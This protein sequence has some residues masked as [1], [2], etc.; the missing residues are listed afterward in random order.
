MSADDYA[1]LIGI[2]HY[3]T[4][5]AGDVSADLQGP[6]NDVDAI[7]AWLMQPD[8]G[9]INDP[10]HIWEFKSA[11]ALPPDTAR[12]TADELEVAVARIDAIAQANVARQK[13]PRVGRRLYIFVSGH[14]YSPKPRLGCLFSANAMYRFTYNV[15]ITGWLSCLQDAAYFREYVLWMDCCMNRYSFL[16]PR[17]PPLPPVN[18]PEPPGANF[19]AFAAQRPLKAVEVPIAED[20]GKYHGVFTWA[21]LEGLRGAAS[22]AN[23]RVTGRSLADWIRNAQYARMDPLDRSN[24]DVAKE[25]EVVQEDASIVFARGLA[26]PFYDVSVAFASSEG[27]LARLWSGVSPRTFQ[28]IDLTGEAIQ[29]SLQPGLYLID[30]PGANLRQGFEVVGSTKVRIEEVGDPVTTVA[31]D[32]IFQLDIDPEDPT[33]EIYVIDSRFALVDANP[34]TLSTPL[35]F[36]LY[37]IKTRVGRTIS[38]KIILHDCDHP[39]IQRASIAL[40]VATVMPISGTTNVQADHEAAKIEGVNAMHA[41]GLSGHRCALMLMARSFSCQYEPVS[42]TT[43]WS[44][45]SIVDESGETVIDLEHDADHLQSC[46]GDPYAVCVRAVEPGT[47]FLK[48]TLADGSVIEQSLVVCDS[49]GLEV[50][51]LRRVRKEDGSVDA[52]PRLSFMMRKLTQPPDFAMDQLTETVRL[53]LADE[54]RILNEE[55]ER[56]LLVEC[57]NPIAG[58]IAGHLLLIERERDPGRDVSLLDTLVRKLRL[59]IGNQHPDVKALA[60]Q[61]S[62]PK[63]RRVGAV[64]AP[65]MFQRSWALLVE[66][67]R[68]RRQLVPGEMWERVQAVATLAPF[69][70]WSTDEGVR[71]QVRGD[72][73]KVISADH[74]ARLQ[75]PA[76]ERAEYIQ[77]YMQQRIG[78]MPK[79]ASL[80]LGKSRRDLHLKLNRLGIPWVG[81]AALRQKESGES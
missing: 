11:A 14:G 30:V 40:P 45:L 16:P 31:V 51:V 25:P 66:A 67:S 65:P 8:G 6:E 21:I 37:K 57:E 79:E 24:S 4:L 5:G 76:S 39:K 22:D 53:A 10:T 62:D 61:C 17:D 54:R 19:I 52:R 32:T 18:S 35:P 74:Q 75:D 36:G 73:T 42:G 7:R 77:Q 49:W 80:N 38:Q 1:I 28:A 34:A 81:L 9:G 55:L 64:L 63:L 48:Q 44:G 13:P 43:P 46:P 12:P 26:K 59:L 60:L 56:V 15:H 29:L 72:L 68:R 41:L 33:A 70:I 47:Y 3:P 78:L 23:G 50:Y 20:S 27:G 58:I 2:N 69:L 71:S